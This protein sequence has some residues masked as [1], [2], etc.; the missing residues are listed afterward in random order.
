MSRE[1]PSLCREAL[2]SCLIIFLDRSDLLPSRIDYRLVGTAAALLHGVDLPANDI[3]ILV[4]RREDVDA[5]GGAMAGFP[6]LSTPQWLPEARQYYGNYELNGVEIGFSTVEVD[7]ERD[8]VETY[9]PGPWKHY[10][11]LPC[12]RHSVPTVA[13]ELRLHTELH[14]NRPDR[15]EPLLQYL[16]D[17]DCDRDLMTRCIATHCNLSEEI[18]ERVYRMVGRSLP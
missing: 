7:S 13:L 6:C 10:S 14:R 5:L 17:H 4:R 9:G 2:R 15:F 3:D 12:G 18:K 8:T 11:N 1:N 16:H